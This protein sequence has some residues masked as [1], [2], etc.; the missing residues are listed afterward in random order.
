MEV[1]WV[2]NGASHPDPE[3]IAAALRSLFPSLSTRD[4]SFRVAGVSTPIP[5]SAKETLFEPK[6]RYWA[7]KSNIGSFGSTLLAALDIHMEL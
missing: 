6:D 5:H 3:C 1:T 7:G 4:K 2:I